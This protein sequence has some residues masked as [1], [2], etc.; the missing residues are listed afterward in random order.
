MKKL[1]KQEILFITIP[2]WPV[3]CQNTK[4][5]NFRRINRQF[6]HILSSSGFLVKGFIHLAFSQDERV[7]VVYF[8]SNWQ[9][10]NMFCWLISA[11][12]RHHCLVQWFLSSLLLRQAHLTSPFVT[13]RFFLKFKIIIVFSYQVVN[14]VHRLNSPTSWS[15]IRRRE[16]S[17]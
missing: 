5:I 8:V 11:H 3:Y 12:I 1:G 2:S 15:L 10:L 17:W 14:D 13:K 7:F 4:T 6:G 16:S 9:T